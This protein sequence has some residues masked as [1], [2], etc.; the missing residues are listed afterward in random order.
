M[1]DTHVMKS[2]PVYK[3]HAFDAE[4]NY[5]CVS[6]VIFPSLIYALFVTDLAIFSVPTMQ[7]AYLS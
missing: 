3:C 4:Q 5:T 6:R 7:L 2:F 1:K